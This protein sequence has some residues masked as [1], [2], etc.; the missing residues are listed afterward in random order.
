MKSVFDTREY[1]EQA[2]DIVET[3]AIDS[4]NESRFKGSMLYSTLNICDA[5]QLLIQK[6]NFVS[7]NI[8][9]RSLFE[10]LFRS[11]WLC[12]AALPEEIESAMMS[13]E[14]PGTKSIHISIE[15]KS[16]L[17]DLLASEKLKIQNIL[18][19]YIH[20]GNQNPLG[21]FSP[22]NTISPNVPDSE[23]SYLLNMVQVTSLIVL[24]EMANMAKS[25]D[26]QKAVM[27]LYADL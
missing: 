11:Y 14:W 21:N 8:L 15:G 22:D 9:L 19:S 25:D 12:R 6:R 27:K 23:V 24:L 7:S 5:M 26:A 1:L 13:D 20:A 10:Y 18:H 17:I 16:N 2:W 3:I 4:D